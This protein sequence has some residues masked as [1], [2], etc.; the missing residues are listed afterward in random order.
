MSRH[1]VAE[2]QQQVS[3]LVRIPLDFWR[4]PRATTRRWRSRRSWPSPAEFERMGPSQFDAFLVSS[5]FDARITA[6]LSEADDH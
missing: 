2:M 3:R 1:E 6:A 4:H 5:G